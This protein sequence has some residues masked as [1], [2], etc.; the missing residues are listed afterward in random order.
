MRRRIVAFAL[1]IIVTLS[2]ATTVFGDIGGGPLPRG[3]NI[4]IGIDCE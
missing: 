4:E 2:F 3:R 1:A